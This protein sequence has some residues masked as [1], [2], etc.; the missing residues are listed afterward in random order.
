MQAREVM[1]QVTDAIVADLESARVNPD[2][3]SV[4]WR[5]V[6]DQWRPTNATTGKAYRGGNR[7]GLAMLGMMR[8]YGSGTWATYKQWQS[9]DAQVRKGERA[10]GIVVPKEVKRRDEETNEDRSAMY[11]GAAA[12]FAAEQV[13]GYEAPAPEGFESAEP[14][15]HAEQWLAAVVAGGQVDFRHAPNGAYYSRVSDYVNVP[16]L[17]DFADA[18]AYYGTAAHELTHWTG[19]ETR[20]AREKHSR[21]GDDKY[22]AEELVAELGAAF[23]C[24]GIGIESAPRPD[25]SQYLGHWARIL[26]ADPRH[27]Y[28][29]AA[30]A[31]KAV[32]MLTACADR[33][34]L[35]AA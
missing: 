29:V 23:V 30:Q 16:A 32:D 1:R 35:V 18:V 31:E 10:V 20:L 15:D 2:E 27:L 19:H 4:P 34:Q 17:S 3:W 11:W 7:V 5:T 8:G 33:A 28:T 22:A 13:N 21:F 25:H 14:I 6:G 12:V 24:A 26:K 9:I